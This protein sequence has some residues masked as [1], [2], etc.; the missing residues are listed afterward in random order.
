MLYEH[1]LCPGA[2]TLHYLN[3]DIPRANYL[4]HCKEPKAVDL[5]A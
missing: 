1:L 4:M 2:I 5:K 3:F